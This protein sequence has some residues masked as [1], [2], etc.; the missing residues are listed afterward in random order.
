MTEINNKQDVLDSRDVIER[1]EE[2]QDDEMELDEKEKEELEALLYL[3]EQGAECS[4]DWEY[5][6]AL[7]RETYFQEYAQDL[8]EECGLIP[9]DNKWPCTCIDWEHAAKELKYDY[10]GIE[11][12]DITYYIRSC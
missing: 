8:A 9:D 4:P 12:N 6:E 1:I 5:G 10:A 2:L 3:A 11:Y 7:V